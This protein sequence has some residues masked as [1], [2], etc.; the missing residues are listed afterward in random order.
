MS[1][2][3]ELV[4]AAIEKIRNLQDYFEEYANQRSPS[5]YREKAE[6]TE[7]ILDWLYGL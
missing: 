5:Y 3:Q 6:K 7:E 4:E 1:E 2:K